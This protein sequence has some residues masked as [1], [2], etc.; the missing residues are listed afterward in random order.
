[1]A[2]HRGPPGGTFARTHPAL[3][4]RQRSWEIHAGPPCRNLREKARD[5]SGAGGLQGRWA[6]RGDGSWAVR[7]RP[8]GA[9]TELLPTGRGQDPPAAQGPA[10]PPAARAYNLR[11]LRRRGGKQDRGRLAL[12]ATLERDR[13][14]ARPRRDRRGPKGAGLGERVLA[15]AGAALAVGADYGTGT[16]GA[17]G[18]EGLPK[19]PRQGR[20]PS[21]R[22]D[23]RPWQP[24]GYRHVLRGYREELTGP[25]HLSNNSCSAS[26]Q[27]AATRV[28]RLQ[29]PL[30]SS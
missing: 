29:W 22:V 12:P 27:R 7:S 18:R 1:M 24:G 20:A 30:N 13:N 10:S 3:R 4:R 17:G 6:G 15:R 8:W 23:D 5:S 9:P 26:R 19:L 11:Q 2:G 21:H 16:L 14:R 28:R 25:W